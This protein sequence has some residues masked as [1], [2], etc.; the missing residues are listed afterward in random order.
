MDLA[1][2]ASVDRHYARSVNFH[3]VQTISVDRLV[4]AVTVR[5]QVLETFDVLRIAATITLDDHPYYDH[6]WKLDLNRAEWGIIDG[7]T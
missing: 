1:S 3:A 4:N 6:V 7:G 5:T 2:S